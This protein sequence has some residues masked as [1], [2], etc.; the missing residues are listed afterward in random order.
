M[1]KQ[2]LATI[3]IL[4]GASLPVIAGL[5]D[6]VA[7]GTLSNVINPAYS[8]QSPDAVVRFY[9]AFP[10]TPL[11]EADSIEIRT[12]RKDVPVTL[13]EG[14]KSIK[15][16][17]TIWDVIRVD[18]LEEYIYK[19]EYEVY[20]DGKKT[21]DSIQTRRMY[22]I[23]G[24]AT[25]I[26]TLY[27][28][29]EGNYLNYHSETNIPQ[30]RIEIAENFFEYLRNVDSALP[31]KNSVKETKGLFPIEIA[32]AP[33]KYTLKNNDNYNITVTVGKN[34]MT[35]SLPNKGGKI[36]TQ[37]TFERGKSYYNEDFHPDF[38]YR[39]DPHPDN[40]PNELK[41]TLRPDSDSPYFIVVSEKG[42]F[43]LIDY[44]EDFSIVWETQVDPKTLWDIV[45]LAKVRSIL[46]PFDVILEINSINR[47][48]NN[49]QWWF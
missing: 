6:Y 31:V 47:M 17:H 46:L 1:R 4:L 16:T 12:E 35:I 23:K 42:R 20:I 44:V 38:S 37:L 30:I 26:K 5:K 19:T 34:E 43:A 8:D 7:E 29:E 3:L 45:E 18:T 36:P 21:N 27:K 41:F 9:R 24:P 48:M 28:D 15:C 10:D 49:D 2:T 40:W 25:R 39:E 33:K 13:K 14:D 22:T 11:D 32:G